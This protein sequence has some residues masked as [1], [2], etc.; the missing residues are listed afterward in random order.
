[1]KKLYL[2]IALLVA[3]PLSL[4]SKV[5]MNDGH[6][7]PHQQKLPSITKDMLL[8]FENYSK[9]KNYQPTTLGKFQI[10]DTNVDVIFNS[11]YGN[12]TP[13]AYEPISGTLF[14]VQSDRFNSVVAG[15]TVLEGAV[16]LYYTQDNGASW[17]RETIFSK[18][19]SVPVNPTIS[20]T[21]PSK[22]NDPSKLS[23]VVF[24]RYFKYNDFSKAYDALGGLYLFNSGNGLSGPFEE[25]EEAGPTINNSGY[26]WSLSKA[27]SYTGSESSLSYF[28]GTLDP[29]TGVQYGMYGVGNLEFDNGGLLNNYSVMPQN[30][31]S[32]VWRPSTDVNSSYNAP[33]YMDVD[34]NGTL[35]AAVNNIFSDNIEVRTLAISKSTD[36]GQTWTD[37]DRVPQAVFDAYNTQEGL[38]NSFEPKP[39]STSGFVVTGVDEYSYV[40]TY[41][42]IV[43]STAE[44]FEDK[45][46]EIYKKNGEWKIQDIATNTGDTWRTPYLLQDT[47]SA[48]AEDVFLD[49]A[50]GYEIQLAKTA[51][52]Q[53]LLLKYI[54]NR[55]ELVGLKEVLTLA[56]GA[57]LDT[58]LTTDIWI[59]HR[60]IANPNSWSAPISITNDI[61]M[62]KVTYIPSIIPSL[63]QVPIIEHV[64]VPFLHYL[65]PTSTRIVNKYPRF[66]E[67]FVVGSY[68]RNYVLFSSFDA[69]AG[70]NIANPAVQAPDG[71][72][73]SVDELINSEIN[74]FN[75]YPNPV[76]SSASITYDIA[77]NANVKIEVFSAMGEL[78]KTVRNY[79]LATPGITA[80]EFDASDLSSG[81]YYVTMTANGK[82]VTKLMNVVR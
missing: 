53:N 74:T 22:S 69:S 70:E 1:M 11:Y 13:M 64:N 33:L 51:D 26:Q 61:W 82:R 49:N 46:V 18:P 21:N 59:A 32:L 24:N 5:G 62:N 58:T 72:I 77:N 55:E 14:M 50:R 79:S 73:V 52:G 28:Y 42:K 4:V 38:E 36:K 65:L 15:D 56:G 40:L 68:I 39:Y 31:G 9:D 10:L 81:V 54:D 43:S 2:V 75:I 80:I 8:N 48:I 30:W 19:K 45:I 34:Q 12:N 78:V 25:F 23:V 47:N 60:S 76:T 67:N 63:T 41:R 3:I 27:L 7:Q 57:Q 66:I 17:S 37:F 16:Y 29:N 44:I 6:L 71:A 35:Y 20:V